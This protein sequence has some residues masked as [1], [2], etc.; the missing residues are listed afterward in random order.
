MKNGRASI[1]S[2]FWQTLNS[3][4][5]VL[6]VILP[7][8][9]LI[10]L[11][12]R[13]ILDWRNENDL[14]D[15]LTENQCRHAAALM[16][17]K[18]ETFFHERANDLSRLVALW[19][20]SPE[21][22]RE[23]SLLPEA[24]RLL[25]KESS[26][27]F[28]LFIDAG[29]QIRYS[30]GLDSTR[31]MVESRIQER[32]ELLAQ[33]KNSRSP[34]L[35]SPRLV[36]ADKYE[37]DLF[38]PVFTNEE[39]DSVFLG[40]FSCTIDLQEG[41]RTMFVTSVPAGLY[42]Q[43]NIGDR[44]VCS[45]SPGTLQ[46]KTNPVSSIQAHVFGRLWPVRV[47]LQSPDLF[48]TQRRASRLRW[49]LNGVF[50]VL[51]FIFVIV[52]LNRMSRMR[53]RQME[54]HRSEARFRQLAETLQQII[55]L[56]PHLIF[57]K[58]KNGRILLANQAFAS[59][60]GSSVE[61][62]THRLHK[63]L[64][65]HDEE[66]NRFLHDDRV[67]FDSEQPAFIAREKFTDSENRI[68]IHQ[69]TRI[70]FIMPRIEEPAILGIS[71]DITK[72]EE[73]EKA[74]IKLEEQLRHSQKMEAIGHLAGGV[75]HDF[76][77]LL[78]GIIG[79]SNL[80]LRTLNRDDV[81][82]RGITEIQKAGEQAA[83]LTRQLLAFS[84]K[85]IMEPKILCLSD[86]V[87]NMK[88]LLR[89][90]I[91][92]DIDIHTHLDM[93][94][95]YVKA[96][97]AQ[98]TQIIMNLGV[99]ARDA[100]PNGGVLIVETDYVEIDSN[101]C[102]H[103]VPITPGSYVLLA[104]SDTGCGMDKETVNRIFEPFFTTKEPGKGTGLGL[105]T[106]YGIVKQSGGYIY[107]YSEPGK[108]TSFKIYFPTVDEKSES[109]RKKSISC[110]SLQGNE[111][112]L[113]VEDDAIVCQMSAIALREYGYTVFKAMDAAEAYTIYEQSAKP[114]HLLL[115]DVVLPRESGH[116]LAEKLIELNPALKVLYMS[117]YTHDAIVNH[118]ILEEGISFLH[119]PFTAETLAQ[120]VREVL[121]HQP[122]A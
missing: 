80:I 58:D 108:G 44:S 43:V 62:V 104:V 49:L 91:G 18:I 4:L 16:S 69:T 70:P 28:I 84:R 97:P 102:S 41:M 35:S 32:E 23:E 96:D 86:L 85:Q 93:S 78:T 40:A 56:V 82:Y 37:I 112:I 1:P 19:H 12:S 115:T 24:K 54:L 74:Q 122:V 101:Y 6:R 73:S 75:A 31:P 60:Y 48:N 121:D 87:I 76:N 46:H 90:L 68:R 111:T 99:N 88:D 42:T 59:A 64:H 109:V 98:I 27:R 61:D 7:L 21:N 38:Y 120:K 66:V 17:L 77:N 118:G 39:N 20:S 53:I 119:K 110:K 65:P 51:I 105:S 2:S 114:I 89:R 9:L 72:Q 52:G 25:L 29:N 13:D 26:C 67:V 33:I 106:V 10:A 71:I 81:N 34:T 95:H 15:E 103:H 113:L 117:G 92:E 14:L 11:V 63:D 45:S 55:D 3:C 36:T 50:S 79:Y 57:A 47:Y 8:I 30:I 83:G 100:M 94:R 116:V 107:V 5:R 22:R